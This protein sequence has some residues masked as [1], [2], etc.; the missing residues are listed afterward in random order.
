MSEQTATERAD[1]AEFDGPHTCVDAV[2][3]SEDRQ[4]GAR[5]ARTPISDRSFQ[6]F[7]DRPAIGSQTLPQSRKAYAGSL[8]PLRKGKRL[9]FVS[10]QDV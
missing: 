9:A 5:F 7:L 2:P 4:L 6:G 1:L 8:R 10:N 3:A